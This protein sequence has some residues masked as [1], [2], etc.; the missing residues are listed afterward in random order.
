MHAVEGGASGGAP[1]ISI[2]VPVLDGLPWLGQQLQALADQHSRGAAEVIVADNGSVDG[3]L[4]VAR[5]F[6]RMQPGFMVLDASGTP[7]AA[8]ARNAGAQAAGG[9]LLAFCD[10]D[11]VVGP[12]WV[13]GCI[14]GLQHADAVTGCFDNATLNGGVA[15]DPQPPATSQLGFLPAGLSSNLAVRRPAFV[16]VGGFDERLSVGE[17]IDLCWRLQLAGYRF[18]VATGAV[19]ARRERARA[20]DVFRQA[21]SYGRCGPL[22]YRRYRAVGARPDVGGA[23]RGWAWLVVRLPRLRH[24]EFRR[25]WVRALGVRLGRIAGSLEQR[26]VFP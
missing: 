24:R 23:A 5:R 16:G 13:Q 12:G 25:S 21:F 15:G 22:L 19:V 3:S 18:G 4:D 7:G 14:D 9:A 2:V 1:V 10:A 8:A 6:A 17:D 11:D 26:V 20:G